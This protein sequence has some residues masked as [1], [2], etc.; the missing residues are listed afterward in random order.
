MD[1]FEDNLLEQLKSGESF[2]LFVPDNIGE[3]VY[4]DTTTPQLEPDSDMDRQMQV[5]LSVVIPVAIAVVGWMLIKSTTTCILLSLAMA[6]AMAIFIFLSLTFFGFDQFVGTEGYAIYSFW[7][8]RKKVKLEERLLFK[9]I[10]SFLVYE[11]SHLDFFFG[12]T[13]LPH[14]DERF[15]VE[16]LYKSG[17]K[18]TLAEITDTKP[19]QSHGDREWNSDKRFWRKVIE[20]WS[21]YK[22]AQFEADYKNGKPISFSNFENGIGDNTRQDFFVISNDKITIGNKTFSKSE[23]INCEVTDSYVVLTT[24][25]INPETSEIEKINDMRIPLNDIGNA[26]VFYRC[27]LMFLGLKQS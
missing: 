15:K 10:D 14:S 18:K 19:V 3:I 4:C 25:E 21:D 8:S 2:F 6:A 26:L 13:I 16:V 5:F 20:A 24:A 23:T 1:T 11:K 22:F 9:S 17:R 12:K 7:G 27:L